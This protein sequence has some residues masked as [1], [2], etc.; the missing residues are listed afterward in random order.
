M[1][2]D[3]VGIDFVG[4]MESG[5]IQEGNINNIVHLS[6]LLGNSSFIEYLFRPCRQMMEESLAISRFFF[7]LWFLF[8]F[9]KTWGIIIIKIFT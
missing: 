9:T 2:V 7:L 6:N 8:A 3:L 1:L 5:N 4:S